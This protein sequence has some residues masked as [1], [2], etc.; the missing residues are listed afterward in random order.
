MVCGE[1]YSF[2][3]DVSKKS[4]WA[5]NKNLSLLLNAFK[6]LPSRNYFST[7]LTIISS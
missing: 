5:D 6:T 7:Y 3:V 2:V 1:I 4:S